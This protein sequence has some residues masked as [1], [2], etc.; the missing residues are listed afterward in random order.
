MKAVK[1]KRFQKKN[2]LYP[3]F[4][5]PF[6]EFKQDFRFFCRICNVAD[7]FLLTGDGKIMMLVRGF[8]LSDYAAVTN[9]LQETLSDGC[10]SETMEAFGRQLSWDGELVLVAEVGGELAGVII[11]TIDH[12]NGYCYRIAVSRSFQRRGVGRQLIQALRQR[13]EQRK[14]KKVLV[15]VDVH[16]ESILPFYQSLGFDQSALERSVRQLSIVNG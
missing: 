5:F 11:G 9:L 6:D 2:G 1:I 7:F 14:V 15:S 13:F 3:V 16:N 12:D 8:R 10:F 4:F